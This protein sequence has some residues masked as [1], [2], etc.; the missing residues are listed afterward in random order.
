MFFAKH[1]TAGFKPKL[2]M[3]LHFCPIVAGGSRRLR[4]NET[5]ISFRGKTRVNLPSIFLLYRQ[6]SLVYP[7]FSSER[8]GF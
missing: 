8:N 2:L 3:Y 5:N 1:L 7:N 6:I 4:N